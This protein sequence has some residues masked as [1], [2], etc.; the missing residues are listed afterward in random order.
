MY[1]KLHKIQPAKLSSY[2]GWVAQVKYDGVFVA[3]HWDGQQVTPISR[4]GK[5]FYK[6]LQGTSC[7]RDLTA[8]LQG[9]EA[10][11]FLAE[12]VLP[13]GSLEVL[14]G[15]VNPNRSTSWTEQEQRQMQNAILHVH[16]WLPA[17]VGAGDVVQV[18]YKE[19]YRRVSQTIRH[20]CTLRVVQSEPITDTQQLCLM[21]DTIVNAGEVGLVLKNALAG[22]SMQKRTREQVKWVPA[23]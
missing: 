20:T 19:R 4:T 16:D 1:M 21:Y 17:G 6:E 13:T 22:Y 15:L 5:R 3:L 9:E 11:C 8:Q 23:Q 12:L 14:S 7:I 2:I 10:Q 18:P